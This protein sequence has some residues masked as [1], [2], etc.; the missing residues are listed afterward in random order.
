MVPWVESDELRSNGEKNEPARSA[1]AKS[2]MARSRCRLALGALGSDLRTV[3][4]GVVVVGLVAGGLDLNKKSFLFLGSGTLTGVVVVVVRLVVV[5]V[6]LLM[7]L[8][9]AVALVGE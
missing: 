7:V 4:V 6:M 9:S 1:K 8:V 2:L 5:V 3:G